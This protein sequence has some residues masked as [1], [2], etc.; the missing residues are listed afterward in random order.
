LVF[1][2]KRQYNHKGIAPLQS[3]MDFHELRSSHLDL[4]QKDAI[5]G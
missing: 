1:L 4:A 2:F 3:L 5:F